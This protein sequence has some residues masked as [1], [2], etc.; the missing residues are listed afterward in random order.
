MIQKEKI[1]KYLNELNDTKTIKI[2]GR[3]RKRRLFNDKRV[4]EIYGAEKN[5]VLS[6]FNDYTYEWLN[7]FFYQVIDHINASDAEDYEE[8]SEEIQDNICEW[9]DSETSV[10]TGVLTEW[11]AD[12]NTNVYYINEVIEEQ[13]EV[14]DGFTLLMQAQYKAIYELYNNALALLID[15]LKAE[16]EE[17]EEV[18]EIEA[19]K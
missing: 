7:S 8:L 11:L 6:P 18:E 14:K 2:N 4:F 3:D 9:A 17:V 13:G 16:F 5:E 15:D 1:I 10:Y 12:R 19:V